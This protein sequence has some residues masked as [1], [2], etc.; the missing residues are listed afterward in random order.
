MYFFSINGTIYISVWV[1]SNNVLW[2]M[3][4][5]LMDLREADYFYIRNPVLDQRILWE[6]IAKSHSVPELLERSNSDML[7]YKS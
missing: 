1:L 2:I 5:F 4:L 6:F 3:L 7:E